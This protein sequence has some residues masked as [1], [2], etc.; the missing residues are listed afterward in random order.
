MLRILIV[1]TIILL[2]E[3]G[4][5]WAHFLFAHMVR[6]TKP[7]V[8]LHFAESAWDFS[9][10][11]RMIGLMEPARCWTDD[12]KSLQCQSMPY[13]MH[14]SLPDEATAVCSEF[15]Y[16]LMN[17]GGAFLL[18]YHAKGAAGWEAAS[19]PSDLEAEVLATPMDDGQLSV[20]VLFH[21]EPVADAELIAPGQGLQTQTYATAADGTVTVPLPTAPLF[22]LRAMIPEERQG[23]HDGKSY[24]MVRHY[25]TLTINHD[26]IRPDDSDG[27]A[28][29]ILHD[30]RSHCGEFMS[31]GAELTGSVSGTLG[32]RTIDCTLAH[33]GNAMH[34]GDDPHVALVID[35]IPDPIA[36]SGP[37]VFAAERTASSGS[38]IHIPD[39]GLTYAVVDRKIVSVDHRSNGHSRR[40]DVLEWSPTDDDRIV[41]TKLLMTE[42]AGD[43]IAHVTILDRK[44][45][46]SHGGH[47]PKSH[48]GVRLVGADDST[49]VSLKISGLA[50]K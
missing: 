38:T 28:W 29:A 4:E 34:T 48:A 13:G 5:V 6:D 41:A 36:Q 23:E 7:K 50:P 32:G 40:V 3:P 2:T 31:E 43:G 19:T 21:G 44:H 33:H 30:A 15:T 45:T 10:N 8:E 18:R 47:V 11:P 26:S 12:G 42:Y 16:G 25:T 9:S 20:T 46:Q 37:I 39:R 49:P 17:R 27:L 1:F 22:A 35:P 14:A 24:E